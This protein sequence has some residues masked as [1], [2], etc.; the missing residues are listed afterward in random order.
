MLGGRRV[1]TPI[2]FF[3]LLFREGDFRGLLMDGRSAMLKRV[4]KRT[5][6]GYCLVGLLFWIPSCAVNPVSGKQELMLLSEKEEIQLGRET[7]V[8]VIKVWTL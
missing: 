3:Y 2:F 5:V 4:M 1:D 6:L 7:D 8:Q